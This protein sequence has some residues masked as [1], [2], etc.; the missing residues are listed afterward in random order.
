MKIRSWWLAL[1]ALAFSAQAQEIDNSRFAEDMPKID[2]VFSEWHREMRFFKDD[3]KVGYDISNDKENLYLVFQASDFQVMHLLAR[4]IIINI[5]TDGKKRDGAVLKY[6]V[7]ADFGN[8][9]RPKPNDQQ[10][11]AKPNNAK[12]FSSPKKLKITGFNGLPNDTLNADSISFIKV[13][14]TM[15]A[16]KG[17]TVELAIP[18][19]NLGITTDLKKPIAMNISFTAE[20]SNRNATTMPNNSMQGRGAGMAGGIGRGGMMGG[21]M[22][23]MANGGGLPSNGF[24]GLE[25]LKTSFWVK[26]V[27]A[28]PD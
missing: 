6:P 18:L 3:A 11:G 28:Q 14:S 2:G 21:G 7:A 24:A 12:P 20:K 1:L 23:G 16:N 9:T 19:K 15:V 25:S 5:N 27:L 17:Y 10:Q 8:E 26:F 13:A 4:G 22:R